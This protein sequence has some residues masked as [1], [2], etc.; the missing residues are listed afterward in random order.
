MTF[1]PITREPLPHPR[2]HGPVFRVFSVLVK[3][4]FVETDLPYNNAHQYATRYK[5]KIKTRKME[6]GK[7]GIW[8]I[9][10]FKP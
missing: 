6:N 9:K 5:M 8:C 3:G 10:P 2:F 4:D 1:S 7:L